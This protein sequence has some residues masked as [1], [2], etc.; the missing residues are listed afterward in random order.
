MK[1]IAQ[2]GAMPQ[3]NIPMKG[4]K[5]DLKRVIDSAGQNLGNLAIGYYLFNQFHNIEYVKNSIPPERVNEEYNILLIAA[6]NF[7]NPSSDLTAWA[8]YLEKIDLP[9]VCVGLGAQAPKYVNKLDIKPGTERFVRILSEKTKCIGV[10]GHFT[11]DLLNSWGIKNVEALGCPTAYFFDGKPVLSP[12]LRKNRSKKIVFTASHLRRELIEKSL[13]LTSEYPTTYIAQ[14]EY[15]F[16]PKLENVSYDE[17]ICNA[18]ITDEELGRFNIAFCG[19]IISWERFVNSAGFAFGS[20]MHGNMISFKSG[21]PTVWVKIDSRTQ[22]L[23]EYH[24]LPSVTKKGFINIRSLEELF[25]IYNK[26]TFE[27]VYYQNVSKYIAHLEV[28]GLKDNFAFEVPKKK[29]S[30]KLS[31]KLKEK[32]GKLLNFGR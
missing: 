22:E 14:D 23:C 24:H 30:G 15:D 16:I 8:N 4:D 21:V 27:E 6:A 25:E 29:L 7:I 26:N 2:W 20:R 18:Q 32:T 10:R 13:Q 3:P 9:V 28:S 31:G 17:D 5:T 19:S 1:K 12:V 11:A